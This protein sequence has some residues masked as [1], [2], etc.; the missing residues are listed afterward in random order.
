[1]TGWFENIHKPRSRR[2]CVITLQSLPGLKCK[3]LSTVNPG[4]LML[5]SS[6]RVKYPYSSKSPTAKPK[7]IKSSPSASPSVTNQVQ[8]LAGKKNLAYTCIS[9]VL[10]FSCEYSFGICRRSSADSSSCIHHHSF[11]FWIFSNR[12]VMKA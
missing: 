2:N 12:Q 5:S 4:K 11:L 8:F 7:K 6:L 9:F 1:M 3:S 10:I